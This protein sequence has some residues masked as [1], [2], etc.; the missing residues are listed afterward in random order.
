VHYTNMYLVGESLTPR[1]Y[2][3][4]VCFSS[5]IEDRGFT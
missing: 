4:S 5:D 3:Y 2:F 1:V